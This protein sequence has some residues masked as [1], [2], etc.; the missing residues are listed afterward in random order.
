MLLSLY[1]VMSKARRY[2]TNLE[3]QSC[4][5]HMSLSWLLLQLFPSPSRV[6]GDA[7]VSILFDTFSFT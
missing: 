5:S 2:F 6:A 3:I 7:Y 1:R 4:L